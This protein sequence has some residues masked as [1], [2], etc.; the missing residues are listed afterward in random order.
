MVLT[1]SRRA[2]EVPKNP[3]AARRSSFEMLYDGSRATSGENFVELREAA[4]GPRDASRLAYHWAVD[5]A[6]G[7]RCE[8][9]DDRYAIRQPG[10]QSLC[11]SR[12]LDLW[13]VGSSL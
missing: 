12:S 3:A 1:M 9:G 8:L 11:D 4:S 13:R 6:L 7:Y 10:R 5:G 2:A